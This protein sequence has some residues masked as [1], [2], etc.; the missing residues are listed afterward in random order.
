MI[1]LTGDYYLFIHLAATYP[2]QGSQ[3]RQHRALSECNVSPLW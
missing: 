1:H 3:E 2:A